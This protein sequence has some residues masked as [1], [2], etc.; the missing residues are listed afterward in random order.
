MNN[1][2]GQRSGASAVHQQRQYSENLLEPSSNGR[3]LQ[4]H[5]LSSSNLIP[6]LQV[7]SF[8]FLQFQFSFYIKILFI[9]IITNCIY[10]LQQ[11]LLIFFLVFG[12]IW[13]LLVVMDGDDL[14]ME[15]GIRLLWLMSFWLE[16]EHLQDYNLYGGGGGRMFRNS[17]QRSFSGGNDYYNVETFTPPKKKNGREEDSP[18]DFSPGLLDLHSFDTELLPEVT[19]YSQFW[20]L[21]S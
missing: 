19:N 4:S 18:G 12:M 8:L 3:W 7:L 2:Q 5:L 16:L 17:V 15:L 1:R 11:P 20:Y 14:V 6:P 9:I 13:I 21:P 10:W